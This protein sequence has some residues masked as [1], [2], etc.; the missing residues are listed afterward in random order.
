MRI[1]FILALISVLGCGRIADYYIKQGDRLVSEGKLEEA[2][3]RYEKALKA[4]PKSYVAHNS[5]GTALF[6]MGDY[7]GGISHLRKAIEL[8]DDFVEG[9]YNLARALSL[10]GDFQ[11][12]LE[13]YRKVVKLDSSYA[14][15][16]LG[17]GEV[18][19]DM[20]MPQQAAASFRR[21]I[22]LS[23]NLIQARMALAAVYMGLGQYD[24]AMAELLKAR[25]IQPKNLDLLG[26][27]ARAAM[28]K[29]DFN[30]AVDLF[31]ELVSLDANNP[32]YRNDYATALMLS[33]RRDQAIS[34]WEAILAMNPPADLERIVRENLSKAKAR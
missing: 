31:K 33:G 2:T 12:A 21:A 29:R 25:E 14:L 34:E 17:A 24:E 8:K 1:M 13:E 23:P 15:A 3:K 16:Y 5:L 11:A 28:L 20:N 7:D 26:M 22:D 4:N 18:F 6:L 32:G 19:A 30:K 10:K 27:A 9:H